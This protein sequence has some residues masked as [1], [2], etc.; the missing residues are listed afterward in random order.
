MTVSTINSVA[1][2]VTNGVTKSFPFYF[3]FLESKDLVVT[4]ISPEGTSSDL[5]MGTHYTVAGAG[6]ENGGS[7][8]TVSALAGPGQLIVSRDMEA[9]QQTSLRNQGKFLAETHEDVFD[10]LTMLIQQGFSIFK[11]ALT[12]PFGRDYFYAENRRIASVKDPINDQ[13]AATKLWAQRYVGEVVGAAQGSINLASNIIYIDPR[14]VPRV[15]QDFASMSD[16]AL[17]SGIIAYLGPDIGCVPRILADKLGDYVH[18]KDFGMTGVGDET[19]KFQ[20]CL[21][22][23]NGRWIHGDTGVA[24]TV[25]SCY[26]NSGQRLRSIN[27]KTKA[28]IEDFVS[29]ITID[30]RTSAKI[31][32]RLVG[33]SID[34][35]RLNQTMIVAAG[36]DGGRHGIRVLGRVEDIRLNECSATNCAGDG[37]SLF[38]YSAS[39]TDVDYKIG[40]VYIRDCVFDWNR[41]HGVSADGC[42][43]VSVRGGRMNNNG[44]DLDTISPLNSGARGVRSSSGDLYGRPITFEDYGLGFAYRIVTIEDLVAQGN[45]GGILF[46]SALT[47][48]ELNSG[49]YL[50]RGSIKLI[51]VFVAMLGGYGIESPAL[52]F[53]C[54]DAT[55]SKPAFSDIECIGCD[56]QGHVRLTGV[57]NFTASGKFIAAGGHGVAATSE[58]SSKIRIDA[59][60]LG[61]ASI[62][63]DVL[64]VTLTASAS[65]GSKAALTSTVV[66]STY[67]V[68]TMR[69][70]VSCTTNGAGVQQFILT[71]PAG[72]KLRHLAS[73]A[74]VPATGAPLFVSSGVSDPNLLN[75]FSQ[76]ADVVTFNAVVDF[77][78]L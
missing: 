28:G 40:A 51:N 26:L 46:Q 5:V 19:N 38:G 16:P 75:V 27:L 58:R 39:P 59:Q 22:A 17:G 64:P 3:K 31:N 12:R 67:P 23:S 25:K 20:A 55:V 29:P 2:F 21:N 10:R 24:Y 48:A 77:Q 68:L 72:T 15:V 49:K 62:E 76:R 53:F 6:N 13:D 73:S 44:R 41:R 63:Y 71:A 50:P 34:G 78:V 4:Y 69:C 18:V 57:R 9:Y 37:L 8:L 74:L 52:T 70:E 61:T 36:E 32:I 1:E 54:N 56:L 65:N 45:I 30:G 60:D 14:G 11:R 66:T 47:T 33:V 35:N 43:N 7:V 42:T